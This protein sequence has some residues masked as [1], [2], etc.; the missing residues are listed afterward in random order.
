MNRLNWTDDNPGDA[1]E[2]ENYPCPKCDSDNISCEGGD[3]VVDMRGLVW[4]QWWRCH[5]C[6]HEWV[7][8]YL[9]HYH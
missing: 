1:D 9:D 7:E 2:L 3:T 4:F 8:E 6:Q 5:D